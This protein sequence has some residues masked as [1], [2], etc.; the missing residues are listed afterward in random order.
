MSLAGD[1]EGRLDLTDV[2]GEINRILFGGGDGGVPWYGGTRAQ[3]G[4]YLYTGMWSSMVIIM[5]TPNTKDMKKI[6]IC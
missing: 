3:Y 2:P 5:L 4:A 6:F 1:A